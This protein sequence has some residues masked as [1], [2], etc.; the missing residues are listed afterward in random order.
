MKSFINRWKNKG[1]EKSD[2]QAFWLD[3]L[4]TVLN[5][6]N[7]VEVIEFEKRVERDHVNFID[8]YIPETRTLI[9]Q[10]SRD[11]Q[12]DKAAA[13]SDGQE[14]TPFGQA[15]RYSARKMDCNM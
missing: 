9:E 8:A 14:L 3:L 15:K 2:T 1:D 13:Q 11:I 6:E 10:K 4:H 12:L 7:P 5:V